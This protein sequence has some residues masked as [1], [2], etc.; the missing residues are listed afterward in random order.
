VGD[1]GAAVEWGL[2]LEPWG[3]AFLLGESSGGND[4]VRGSEEEEAPNGQVSGKHHG[5]LV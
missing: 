1:P 4:G 3:V 5:M 2:L